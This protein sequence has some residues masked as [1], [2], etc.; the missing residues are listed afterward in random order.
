MQ[1]APRDTK[2]GNKE[3]KYEVKFGKTPV[4]I[5]GYSYDLVTAT[6]ALEA[7]KIAM[8]TIERGGYMTEVLSENGDNIYHCGKVSNF[9]VRISDQR[10][11]L[12]VMPLTVKE[13]DKVV[14]PE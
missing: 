9:L 1:T 2:K 10:G 12:C 6:G 14:F 3:M 13:T 8:R 11:I 4:E 7:A 5:I